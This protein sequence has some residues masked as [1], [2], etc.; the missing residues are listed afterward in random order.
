VCARVGV[1]EVVDVAG[2]D[3]LQAELLRELRELRQDARLDVEV[4]V[5]E[6]DVDVVATERLREPVELAFGVGE[7][8]LLECLADAPREAAESAISPSLC[9]SRSSQSTRGL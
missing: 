1:A 2:R 8:V 9:A 4:R 7:P 3:R 6:L 5:L